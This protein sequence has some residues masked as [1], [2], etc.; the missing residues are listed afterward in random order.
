MVTLVG[1]QGKWM[2]KGGMDDRRK[3]G[4]ER[5]GRE[6]G[7]DQCLITAIGDAASSAA[8]YNIYL[9]LFFSQ[10]I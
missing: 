3:E 4:D 1:R 2:R 7:E 9:Y 6:M 5:E 10:K 8:T